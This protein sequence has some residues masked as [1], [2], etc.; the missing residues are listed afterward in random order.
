MR[1]ASTSANPRRREPQ[2]ERATL[3]RAKFLE[4]AAGLIGQLGYEAVTMTAIAEQAEASIGTLYDYFPDKTAIAL[5][6]KIQYVEESDAHWKALLSRPAG[7][8]QE[9]L[10]EL[11]VEGALTLVKERPAYLALMGGPVPYTRS[12]SLRRPL[13]KT[14]VG[15]LRTMNPSLAEDRAFI[16][17]EVIVQLIK[18]LLTV[19]REA[20]PRERERVAEE[21]KKLFRLYLVETLS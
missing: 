19:Y 13:R 10:A 20:A 17:A 21:F 2:Q 5:A 3:R 7:M 6:L 4:V 18:G 12:P 15:A 11:F 9:E 14:I 1:V 8:T 16:Y